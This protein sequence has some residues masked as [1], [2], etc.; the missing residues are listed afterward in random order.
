MWKCTAFRQIMVWG[1]HCIA[2]PLHWSS[3]QAGNTQMRTRSGG[4]TGWEN[5]PSLHTTGHIRAAVRLEPGDQ[6]ALNQPQLQISQEQQNLPFLGFYI[7]SNA[8]V[9]LIWVGA[10]NA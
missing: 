5:A 1:G 2:P 6:E 8:G 4:K 3:A 9:G 10:S 7:N